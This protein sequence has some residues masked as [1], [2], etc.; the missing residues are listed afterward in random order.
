MAYP[1][2]TYPAIFIS[3]DYAVL[4]IG[5]KTIATSICGSIWAISINP[6]GISL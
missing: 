4:S 3:C 1:Y 5:C 2:F 6:N